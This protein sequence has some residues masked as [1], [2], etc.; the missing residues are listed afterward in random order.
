MK[1]LSIVS[2][3]IC[4]QFLFSQDYS[5]CKVFTSDEGLAKLDQLGVTV[6]HGTHKKNTF[7]ISD[8]SAREIQ[9]MRDNGFQLEVLIE[10]VQ[11]F[12]IN[13]NKGQFETVSKNAQCDGASGSGSFSP[14]VPSNFNLGS[15]GGFFTYE[16]FLQEIDDMRAQYPHLIS[17]KA[18][19]SNFTTIEGR[20]IYWLRISDNPAVDEDEKEILYSSIH[21]AREPASLSQTIFYMWYLLENYG[22]N[23]EVTF[24]VNNT[25]MYFV[26]CLNPDGYIHNQTTNPNGGG[27]W[28]KNRRNNG[29]S[30]GVD[31]NRNYSYGW[32]TTGIST[33]PSNDTYPGTGP[34]S[35]PETQAMK[36]FCENRN[37]LLAFNAH[38]YSDMILFPIGT[39]TAEFAE[40]HDYF[41][42]F[43][44]HMTQ[45]NGYLAQKSSGLYPASGD[46]DDYMYLEDLNVKPKIF[47]LTPEIGSD[48]DGFWPAQA[49]IT[50]ICQEM[51]FPNLI[52]SHLAHRYYEVKDIDPTTVEGLTGNF[53][54]S[55]MRLGLE[56]GV[57][58]VNI[59]PL[60]GIESVG[61]QVD[62]TLDIMELTNGSISYTLDSDI[63]FGDQIKYVLNT[64][65]PGWTKRDT[66]SKT[67]G[68][69]TLQVLDDASNTQNWTGNWSTTTNTFVSPSSSFTDSPSGNYLN[70]TTRTY[71]FNDV[72]DL[73]NASAAQISFFAKWNIEK[74]YDFARLEISIDNG[75]SWIG[76]CGLYTSVGSSANGS[77][78]PQGEPVYDGVQN[79]WV[80]EEINLSD[81]LGQEILARF[82]LKSD[83]GVRAD[84]FYFDDFKISYNLDQSAGVEKLDLTV[85]IIPNPANDKTTI[86]L[87]NPISTGTVSIYDAAGKKVKSIEI[88]EITNKIEIITSEFSAGFYT[89]QIESSGYLAPI[90]KMLV[91][92]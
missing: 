16:Q 45:Y 2:F 88:K 73:T 17:A 40:D 11:A 66:I 48:S 53:N 37:F 59:T 38:T 78:Q 44:N 26:P 68:S 34:F 62:Y 39:T 36:W 57:V 84:G 92:H 83:G 58:S 19:I 20:P 72:I 65:Y 8:F 64:V 80:L 46:S 3:L 85:K 41:Q 89:I 49:N 10:D 28:R 51:V 74:S 7:F 22:T 24:L 81:Y 60:Q 90:S 32:G 21:H 69:L 54:H 29:N 47:A 12:Y 56:D 4:S 63:Q 5:R 79:S 55:A 13:Q 75:S 91:A 23:E 42:A 35:E 50:E 77:V 82:I 86:S 18:P 15:M 27:M 71:Q 70:N 33:N 67:F 1:L 87:G 52:L 25:E 43:G 76:Q 9:I 31:L 61:N 6:D 30:Y 14:T